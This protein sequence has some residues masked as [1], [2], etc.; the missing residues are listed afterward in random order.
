[1]GAVIEQQKSR[2]AGVPSTSIEVSMLVK[3]SRY[4]VKEKAEKQ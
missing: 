1:M 3:S 4:D 2:T